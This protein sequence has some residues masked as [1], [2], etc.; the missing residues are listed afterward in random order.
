MYNHSSYDAIV[1]GGG[2]SGLMSALTLG[3]KG[4]NILLLEKADIL[5]GNCRTYEPADC[6]GWRVDTGIHAITELI[7]GPLKQLKHYFDPG[8]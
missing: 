8:K 5:G 1:V 4:N 3:K 7:Y 6:P 2:I